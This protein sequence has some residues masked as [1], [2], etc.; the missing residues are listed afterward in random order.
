VADKNSYEHHI[1]APTACA[2]CTTFSKLC[3]VIE[4]VE[5]IKKLLIIF[6]PTH[7]CFYRV[8]RK[9]WRRRAVSQQ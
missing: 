2:R 5:I 1:F 8:Q 4:D 7:S 9:I 3:V 6:D